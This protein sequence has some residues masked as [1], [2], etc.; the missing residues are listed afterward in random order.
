VQSHGLAITNAAYFKF[1]GS[2]LPNPV[3]LNSW[4]LLKSI[5][6]DTLQFVETDITTTNSQNY[7][8]TR[9]LAYSYVDVIGNSAVPSKSNQVTIGRDTKTE[10]RLTS[11]H[12]FDVSITPMKNYVWVFDS[13]AAQWKPKAASNLFAEMLGSLTKI[14]QKSSSSQIVDEFTALDFTTVGVDA[15]FDAFTN[16]TVTAQTAKSFEVYVNGIKA[17]YKAHT[18]GTTINSSFFP[19]TEGTYWTISETS[20]GGLGKLYFNVPVNQLMIKKNF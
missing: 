7:V 5:H 2:N 11:R 6:A 15:G 17:C 8:I 3:T 12:P 13:T 4:H 9:N 18:S 19:T 14:Y 16:T 1:V 20:G 10:V